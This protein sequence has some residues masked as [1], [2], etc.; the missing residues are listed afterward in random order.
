MMLPA[1]F[2]YQKELSVSRSLFI[3][4]D[5]YV[6]AGTTIFSKSIQSKVNSSAPKTLS[7]VLSYR[8][9]PVNLFFK[10]T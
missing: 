10:T 8:I 4:N 7:L 2:A 3:F 5:S 6:P 1:S 9:I